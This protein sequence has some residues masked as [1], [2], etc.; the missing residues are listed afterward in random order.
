MNVAII[1]GNF[2]TLSETFVLNHITGLI[3]LGFDVSIFALSKSKEKE[4]HPDINKYG[5][6]KRVTYFDI[7]NGRISRFLKALALVSW[8]FFFHPKV[9][10]SCFNYKKYHTTYNILNNLFKI[11]PFLGKKSEIVH[12]HFGTVGLELLFLKEVFGNK[13]KYITTFHGFDISRLIV[14]RGEHVYNPLFEIGDIFLPISK[15][16]MNK[17]IGLGCPKEKIIVQHMGVDTE[18]IEVKEK[19]SDIGEINIL[20][21]ARLVEKKGLEYSISAVA[22]LG[23]KYPLIKYKIIGDGFL[24]ETLCKLIASVG[25]ENYIELVGPLESNVVMNYVYN[26]DIFILP[27]VTAANGDQEGIPV[28]LMEA[29]AAGLP[30]ISTFHSG[31][32]ELVKDGESGFLV[33]E[34]DVGALAE[35]LE[36]LVSHPEI[37]SKM[38]KTGRRF[39]EENFDIKK[40]N[41]QLAKIYTKQNA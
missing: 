5:L 14:E 25:G 16:W 24:K 40:L 17:L 39:I 29:M 31:I 35:K 10:I 8:H 15:L 36:Y 19:F 23:K 1:V 11:G 41:N 6:L 34:R 13:I 27:S 4:I 38:G 30:V 37:W 12:C 3:D 22:R 33:P 28:S 20:T 21:T 7:P 9:I 26:S 32:P 18:K 2:P